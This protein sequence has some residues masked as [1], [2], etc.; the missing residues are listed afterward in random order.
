V[1]LRDRLIA[2]ELCAAAALATAVLLVSPGDMSK[3]YAILITATGVL[4]GLMLTGE[5]KLINAGLVQ[6][7]HALLS[8]TVA[9]AALN[10]PIGAL[11]LALEDSSE[12]PAVF[13]TFVL[14][15]TLG[16]TAQAFSST[17]YYVQSDKAL[18]MRS[19]L[20][21]ASVKIAC[22]TV[23]AW[24]SELTWALIGMTLGA[25]A[26]FTLN[27]RCLP[28][29]RPG[30]ADQRSALLSSL[31]VAY[32]L[33]RAVSAGIR[34]G[35]SALFGPLIASFLVIEQLVG[36]ANSLFEK[37]FVRS[38]RWRPV[39]RLFK[40]GYLAGM[41][42]FVPWLTSQTFSPSDRLSLLWLTIVA[43]AG[44]L[45]LSEMYAALERRGQRYVAVGSGAISMFCACALGVAW[46][47]GVLSQAALVSYVALPGATFLFYWISASHARDDPQR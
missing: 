36:G 44:L 18:V 11:A 46:V 40:A 13:V 27:F 12:T 32:G 6:P 1:A 23:A 9:S 34:I 20:L 37:Y 41:L 21:S 28:W 19:K 31:G 26:E 5:V 43:C 16:T 35:L 22:A 15:S 29:K 4:P 39:M 7:T 3:A 24:R 30:G 25:I 38:V 47:A 42:A 10:V 17:W 2:A 33:S 14:I 45:P 8:K